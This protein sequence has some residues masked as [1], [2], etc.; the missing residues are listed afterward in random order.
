MKPEILEK[1][2]LTKNESTVYLT[3]LQIG[4]SKS[5]KILKKSKLN[6][7][8]IYEIL[9]SLKLKGLVS[10]SVI[11]NIKHF[12]S[13]P[14]TQILEYIKKKKQEIVDEENSIK[15]ALP[16]LEKLQNN[17]KKEVQAV[18]YMGLR[19]I[20]T[21]VDE[22][23]DSMKPGEEILAMGVTKLKDTKLNLFWK[24]WS[25][26]RI[27]RKINVKMIFSEKSDYLQD[28][29][30]MKYTQVRTLTAFT[31]V[32]VDVFGKDKVLILNYP[33]PTSCILIYDKNTATSFTQFFEQMWKTAQK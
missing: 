3:L 32:T 20:K 19:G 27:Q 15:S 26:K 11:N 17:S 5:G 2:G 28:F 8:K 29:K 14:P 33:E 18:T 23:L 4:T 22:A 13:A 16:M 25:L 10:E 21:A 9:E 31:P 30:K 6:S 7:G 12:T 1:I 24:S